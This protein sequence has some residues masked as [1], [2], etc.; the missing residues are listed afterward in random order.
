MLVE[1]HLQHRVPRG[2]VSSVETKAGGEEE[3]AAAGEQMIL[4]VGGGVSS[5]HFGIGL[6]QKLGAIAQRIDSP[7]I[8][9]QLVSDAIVLRAGRVAAELNGREQ[10]NQGDAAERTSH[11]RLA[12]DSALEGQ[13]DDG[14]RRSRPRL[15]RDFADFS[16][17]IGEV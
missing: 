12:Q 16:L 14:I 15:N 4:Y 8:Q 1:R 13:P 10:R 7:G 3:I 17:R 5:A 2:A 6:K 9:L 11:R